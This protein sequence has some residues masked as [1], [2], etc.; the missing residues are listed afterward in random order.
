MRE[1]EGIVVPFRRKMIL[2]NGCEVI[3]FERKRKELRKKPSNTAVHEAKHAGVAEKRKPGS[4]KM[5]SIVPGPGYLG[6]TEMHSMDAVAAAAPHAHGMS[7]TGFDVHIIGQ[8]GAD[9]HAAGAAARVIMSANE[10]ET[11]EIAYALE[12]KKTM[13][14]SEIRWAMQNIDLRNEVVVFIF[15][16]EGKKEELIMAPREPIII[17]TNIVSFP[18]AA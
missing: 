17:P 9:V 1:R 2:E 5:A 14:G 3:S 6:I 8:M 12:E 16:P 13:S 15:S 18:K 7:G 4:V 11:D 10:D